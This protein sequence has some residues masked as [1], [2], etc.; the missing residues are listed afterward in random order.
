MPAVAFESNHCGSL[1]RNWSSV[2]TWTIRQ[3]IAMDQQ[4]SD[5]N[6]PSDKW[7]QWT[8]R[9]I[10]AMDQ[11]TS[12]CNGPTDKWLQRLAWASKPPSPNFFHESFKRAKYYHLLALIWKSCLSQQAIYYDILAFIS[13]SDQSEQVIHQDSLDFTTKW[14]LSEQAA[15]SVR[16]SR[17]PTFPS[18]IY[19]Y[20]F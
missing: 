9:Q 7:L 2:C 4:I 15:H 12:D 11:Q 3:M 20:F 5:C 13:K 6:E 1:Q 19:F 16:V 8:I 18:R 17:S 10:T 14:C